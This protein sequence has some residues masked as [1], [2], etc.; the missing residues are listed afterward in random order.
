MHADLKIILIAATI[1]ALVLFIL[2]LLLLSVVRRV[3]N[4]RTYRK[5]DSLR[6]EYRDRLLRTL[7]RDGATAAVTEFSARP[8]S[9]AWRACEDVL[10]AI[11]AEGRFAAEAAELFQRLGYAA[12]Y[13]TRLAARNVLVRASAIDKLGRMRCLASLPK[14]LPLLDAKDPETLSVTVRA[15]GRIGAR[16]GLAAIV[17]RLPVL[18]GGSFV[19]RKAMENAL[20]NFGATAIPV[21]VDCEEERSD[22]WVLS[23]ILETLSHLPPD[24]RSVSLAI[25]HL[26]SPNAEVRSKA[27]KLLGN[28]GQMAPRDPA[29]LVLPLLEDPVW[30]V[31]L[32]AARSV[33]A[34]APAAAAALKKLLFDEKWLVRGQAAREIMR[35]GSPAV[36]IL[37]DALSTSDT[38]V[39]GG[40][41]EEIEKSGFADLL[42]RNLAAGDGPLRAKSREILTI[43]QGLHFSTPLHEYLSNGDDERIKQEIRCFAAGDRAA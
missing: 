34:L 38:Y 23:C 33:G 1:A 3:R 35:L 42:I 39:K 27:L 6:Q 37:L 4:E 28:S 9:L 10:F 12:H 41:C 40:I 8:G 32:Q 30:F 29:A 7:E 20:L 5:L 2:L 15:L 24:A 18:L 14:L 19:T 11:A 21:L 13:E 31:R 17:Q 36:D 26:K 16:E 25:G 22:P 43:M